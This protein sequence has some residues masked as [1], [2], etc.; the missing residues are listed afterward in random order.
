MG[1]VPRSSPV[2]HG[3]ASNLANVFFQ[4]RKKIDQD[5]DAVKRGEDLWTAVLPV[6][7]RRKIEYA[8]KDLTYP[9][10]GGY[11]CEE[12][13]IGLARGLVL[14][15]NGYPFLAT[16]T[17]DSEDDFF[18]SILNSREEVVYSQI[19]AIVSVVQRIEETRNRSGGSKVGAFERTVNTA[20]RESW[21]KCELVGSQIVEFDSLEMHTAEIGR[22]H[23]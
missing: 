5:H 21:V 1:P 13:A 10:L 12:D 8:V 11:Y 16:A 19:E 6:E 2:S 4:R 15:D 18:H 9:D 7:T 14:R 23:V 3:G 17:H 20:L 22:A